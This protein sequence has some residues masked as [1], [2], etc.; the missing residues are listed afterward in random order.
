MEK[1]N[2]RIS[3]IVPTY[4]VEKYIGKCLDSLVEQDYDNYEV[5]VINDGS[6]F[7]EQAIIDEY[8]KKYPQIIKSYIKENGGYGS[9]LEMGIALSQSDYMLVCDPDDYLDKKALKT[10]AQYQKGSGAELVVGAK[11]LVYSDNE[12]VKYD[13]SF[14]ED[15]GYLKDKKLYLKG[16][17]DF[18]TLYFMEPSPHAKLY[19]LNLLKDLKFPH[20]VAY[21][22]NLLY[23]YT[24]SKVQSVTYCSE[25]LSYYLINREGNTR[26][27]LKPT[28]IDAWVEVFKNIL[29]QVKDGE[30][31]FYYRMFEGFYA[32]FYKVEDI[33]GD[34]EI[35]K[36][37]YALVYELIPYFFNYAALLIPYLEKD[38]AKIKEQKLNLLNPKKSKKTYDY[39]VK[40]K[41][42]GTLK[43]R[44]K[45]SIMENKYLHKVYD[46]YH[47]FAKYIYAQ[48]RSKLDLHNDVQMQCINENGTNFF[49]YY[50]KPCYA[51]GHFL[52]HHLDSSSLSLDQEVKIMVDDK[53]VSKTTAWNFQQG[54][55]ATWFDE[56]H[57]M[58]NFFDGE[59]YRSKLVDIETLESKIY[60]FPIYSL[61]KDKRF[62]LSLNFSRL[63][64]LRPDYGYINLPYQNLPD[65]DNDG[66]YYLDLANDQVELYLS[67]KTI[68]SFIP[69]ESMIK[70]VHKVNH[71]D[72]SPDSDKVIFLHRW[73]LNKVKY[74]RL[75]LVEIATKK[76]T[77]LADNDMVSHMAWVNN[78][79]LFG[80]LRGD[81][82]K[83]GYFYVDL[84]GH[85]QMFEHPLLI[86]DGHPTIINERFI[87]T[88]TYP[89]YTCKSKLYL[90]D[91][92]DKSV[93]T[94]GAFYSGMRYRG[95][96]RDDL[97]P[98]CDL[99][100]MGL[101]IDSVFSGKRE[102]YH[103]DLDKLLKDKV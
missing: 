44:I 65:D 12:E 99:N 2:I 72:I 51:Y 58:H 89:D 45:K 101:T 60:S 7:G 83:D 80:Y 43:G 14:N 42:E 75:I 69:K 68:K 55:M 92:Q 22:D 93:S 47:Y 61:S 56:R 23:F 79:L 103:L 52:Y 17:K 19:P 78:E 36:A 9:V 91:R 24:L 28:V 26:T 31:I 27:D 10:L 11:N 90:I 29:E 3:V 35:K 54:S 94:L 62:A 18:E 20:K 102:V 48:R 97:H 25:A 49:G 41:L 37:K 82:G 86:D 1:R 66:I 70:A 21:T 40:A 63:A 73:F 8:Q 13:K 39:M 74:T 5:L 50:D 6:P 33:K 84:N 100:N 16:D 34:K 30:A 76:M 85:K 64:K 46:F 87:V 98:R 38:N 59:Q 77:V 81:N 32:I 67:L 95:V 96:R 88:D 4:N 53:E 15:F 71:I 57:I